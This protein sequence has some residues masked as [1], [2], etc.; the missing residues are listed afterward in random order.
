MSKNKMRVSLIEKNGELRGTIE[1]HGD[2]LFMLECLALIVESL[3]KKAGLS[4]E[5][6][7]RDLLSVVAGKVTL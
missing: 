4:K 7:A 5:E 1:S 3:A 6:V 2:A